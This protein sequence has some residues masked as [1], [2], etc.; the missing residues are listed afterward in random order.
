MEQYAE[1]EKTG[2]TFEME[3]APYRPSCCTGKLFRQNQERIFLFGNSR[4]SMTAQVLASHRND[5]GVNS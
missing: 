3:V 4:G 5:D 2:G 1:S